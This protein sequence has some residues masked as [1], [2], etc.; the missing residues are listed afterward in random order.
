MTSMEHPPPAPRKAISR[1]LRF[2]ILRRDN[3]TCRY[4]HATDTPLVIDHV[5]PVA[6]GGTD[7]PSNLVAACK[8]CN[9]GKTS[10]SPDGALVAEVSDEQ[11]RWAA[12]VKA[13]ADAMLAG[14]DALRK[15]LDAIG[16][17]WDSLI[18]EYRRSQPRYRLPSDWRQT[19][20]GL[21]TAGLPDVM[22]LDSMD[23]AA[24]RANLDNIFRYV[25]GVA[26]NK[27]AKLH[28]S[29]TGLLAQPTTY[30]HGTLPVDHP[31]RE[32]FRV[33]FEAAW[34]EPEVAA[35]AHMF[36]CLS[37]VVDG[38]KYQVMAD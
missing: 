6:L 36:M 31:Y 27:L 25:I 34:E 10:T 18:P 32:G 17:Y 30:D 33:G 13:A 19:I 20:A 5:K 9:A 16:D 35:G 37:R 1:R 7:D 28:E 22:V 3:N 8:D 14:D 2:E 15:R 26:N 21:L 38:I 23:V 24:S 12:A 11:M 4:C 29:A